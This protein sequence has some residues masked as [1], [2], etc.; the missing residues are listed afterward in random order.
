MTGDI[1]FEG[2]EKFI[3]LFDFLMNRV[4]TFRGAGSESFNEIS[5]FPLSVFD[6]DERVAVVLIS[7][8]PATN[9]NFAGL[10]VEISRT[11]VT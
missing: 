10:T 9:W 11:L 2:S 6:G 1:V 4:R 7:D 5:E 8:A 3:S